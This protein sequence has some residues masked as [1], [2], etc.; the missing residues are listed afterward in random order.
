MW[1][2]NET[3]VLGF[4]LLYWC[5][6]IK[7]FFIVQL[8]ETDTNRKFVI[9]HANFIEKLTECSW[10]NTSLWILEIM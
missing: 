6:E 3:Y 4:A 1:F 9:E 8:Q 10:K 2:N 5:K 7:Q